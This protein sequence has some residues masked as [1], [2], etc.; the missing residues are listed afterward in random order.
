M[1][2]TSSR[3]LSRKIHWVNVLFFSITAV[4]ALSLTPI[5]LYFYG[6]TWSIVGLALAYTALT[7]MSIT[8]GYHRFLSH[9]SYEA[10]PLVKLGFLLFGAGAFQGSALQWSADHR[11][12]HRF[13]DTERD[14]H[15]IRQGFLWAHIGWLF[16]E[17]DPEV[18]RNY[19]PDLLNDKLVMWQHRYY[20]PIA[21]VMCFGV[22][23]AAGFA[24][25]SPFGG[26]LFGGLLRVVFGNHST[27]FINS[28]AHTFGTRPYSEVQTARDSVLLAFMAFGEGYHNYHHQFASDYRNGIR[29]YQWDPTKWLIR[30]LSFLGLTTRLKRIP[31]VEIQRVKM[32]VEEHTLLQKGFPVERLELLKQRREAAQLRM[33]EIREEFLVLRSDMRTQS[34]ARY[35]EFQA[36]SMERYRT[37]ELQYKTRLRKLKADLKAS[38]LERK[39][40]MRQWALYLRAWRRVPALS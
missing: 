9:R 26:L 4:L 24:I 10:S 36:Q 37:L 15:N 19:P 14:P 34:Q 32:R 11:R 35:R 7:L 21:I 27:F 25:G 5:Y 13:V 22:P 3:P 17:E 18:V 29:W 39:L 28:Y 20:V 40:A 8:A 6:I 2:H 16:Y 33:K 38:R 31:T 12:H 1:P 23:L 30:S